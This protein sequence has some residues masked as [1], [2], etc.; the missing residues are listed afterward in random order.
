MSVRRVVPERAWRCWETVRDHNPR[1]SLERVARRNRASFIFPGI[2]LLCLFILIR[3]FIVSVIVIIFVAR[4]WARAENQSL[5]LARGVWFWVC[6]R[7]ARILVNTKERPPTSALWPSVRLCDF[8][9][10]SVDDRWVGFVVTELRAH[11]VPGKRGES[12]GDV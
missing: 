7:H 6:G 4:R 3:L 9:S 10:L 1:N 11:G 5:K 12:L 8:K 2:Q